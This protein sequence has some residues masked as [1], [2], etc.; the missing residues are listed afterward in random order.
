MLR[1]ETL[2]LKSR[3]N[4]VKV[5]WKQGSFFGFGGDR[6][7]NYILCTYSVSSAGGDV[8][9]Y[10]QSGYSVPQD[11]TVD[12]N[13]QFGMQE[14]VIFYVL[15]DKSQKPYQHRFRSNGLQKL[16]Y[17]ANAALKERAGVDL[18]WAAGDYL[19]DL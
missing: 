5:E 3:G 13:L 7:Q 16:A 8:P 15:H 4:T 11:L 14:G 10:I 9:V 2:K 6:S 18:S 19:R 17:A 12:G 1:G